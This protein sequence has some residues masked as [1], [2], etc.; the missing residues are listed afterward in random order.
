[1]RQLVLIL[2]VCV[3]QLMQRDVFAQTIT[4][5]N[6]K[7]EWQVVNR[8]RFFRDPGLFN[9][10]EDA[11]R[12][13]LSHVDGTNLNQAEKDALVRTTS[14]LGIEHVLNDR[15]IP[16]TRLLRTKFDWRGWGAKLVDQTCWDEDQQTHSGCGD[17]AN[18]VLPQSHDVALWLRS[19][20]KNPVLAESNCEWRVGASEA[21]VAP[22]DEQVVI[23]VPY[24]D[25]VSV[26]V[27]VAGETGISNQIAVRDLLIAGLGDS[28][29]SGEG[30]PDVPVTLDQNKRF[31]NFYPA[32]LRNDRGGNA[33]WL[34][35]K[36]H[37]S[38]YSYQLRAA[39][40]IAIENKQTSVT[41]LGYACS[42]ATIEAGLLGPQDYVGYLSDGNETDPS[43]RATSGGKRDSQLYRLL[44]DICTEELE[45]AGGVW[46]CPSENFRR[47]IDFLFLSIGGN[48]IGFSNLVAWSTLRRS[49]SSRIAKFFGA[50]VSPED[51][52]NA[53]Q[54]RLPGLY[55]RLSRVLSE[56]V[57]I[58]GGDIGFDASRVV[59]GSYPDILVD[60]TGA[61]CGVVEEE[62]S[63]EKIPANQSL[64]LFSSW[65]AVSSDKV[66]RAHAQL[67]RLHKRM[68]SLAEDH[69]WTFA[70]RAYTD[71]PFKGHGFCAQNKDRLDDPSEELSIPCWQPVSNEEA[72]CGVTLRSGE[73]T[74]RP[75]NPGLENY[76]YA[77]RQRWVR[78]F[79]D[80]YMIVNEK[81]MTRDGKVA[82][83]ASAAIFS[84]T[85]GAM[86]PSAEGQ[87]AMADAMLI[88]LRDEVARL[89]SE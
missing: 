76:P 20:V 32:R 36:C 13:Y 4:V 87:A 70:G 71:R 68:E 80:A 72:Y 86:H 57:P 61:V 30:N 33:V 8:F 56:S 77:L 47:P 18:Y 81:V 25:G 51:F 10:H 29:A 63:E 67:A 69:G 79:N 45:K 43:I 84:E 66:T 38:V 12:Q 55:A 5:S 62:A 21:I 65:L 1:V 2:V 9:Q 44:A 53:M 82:D 31:R 6:V 34:D 27:N 50:T 35:Q 40:Q 59:L 23:N 19:L 89:I 42:G 26:S 64:D 49:V 75:F 39:L 48:D 54:D 41:F 74:W 52:E 85:T 73:R 37:R 46:R 14:V 17:V 3:L 83:R 24:P 16:F 88:D 7:I 78:T 15:Y 60:E 11:W 22:C 58:R 28:F